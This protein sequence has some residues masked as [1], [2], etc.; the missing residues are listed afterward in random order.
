M[1]ASAATEAAI[2]M[3]SFQSWNWPA[4]GNVLTASRTL[5]RRAWAYSTDFRN[6]SGEK[7][8]PGKFLALVAF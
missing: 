2:A 8:S 7:F 6:S 5:A 3:A 4:G 1:I